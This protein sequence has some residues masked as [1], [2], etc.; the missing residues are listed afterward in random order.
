MK[1]TISKCVRSRLA[2]AGFIAVQLTTADRLA[3]QAANSC[4]SN[5]VQ[6]SPNFAQ[7]PDFNTVGPCG[8]STWWWKG[9]SVCPPPNTEASA[10]LNWKIHSSNQQ[11]YIATA[12]IASTL[13]IG[14][15][16]RMLHIYQPVGNEGGIYQELPAPLTKAIVSVWVYVRRGHIELSP[17]ATN[18]AGPNS[19]NTKTNEWELLRFCIDGTPLSRIN[20]YNVDVSGADFD[21]D[22]VEIKAFN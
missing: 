4:P 8:I 18:A 5:S 20:I 11:D 19:Y 7:N 6:S 14:G 9:I 21:V 17:N 2:M 10:A 22:R 1:R 15:G 13:C 3:A 12:M 16:S